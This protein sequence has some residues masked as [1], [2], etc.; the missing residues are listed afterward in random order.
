MPKYV[1]M[2]GPHQHPIPDELAEVSRRAIAGAQSGDT[3]TAIFELR[4]AFEIADKV[5]HLTYVR[6]L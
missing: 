6:H 2:V 3:D 1:A 4:R 5:G